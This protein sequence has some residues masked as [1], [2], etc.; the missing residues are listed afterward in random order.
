MTT[1]EA[2]TG[3]VDIVSTTEEVAVAMAMDH[4]LL[5]TVKRYELA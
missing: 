3:E 1:L 4:L 5:H 2:G